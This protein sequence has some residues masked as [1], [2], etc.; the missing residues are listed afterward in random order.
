[1]PEIQDGIIEIESLAR[2]AGSRTKMAVSTH[3]ES[4]D[5]VGA[6]VGNRGIRVQAVVDELFGEKIDIIGW[7]DVTEDNISSAL[8]PAKAE[9]IVLD[10]ENKAATAIV[11]DYQ[12]S[13]AIG[14]E[15]QNVRLAAK[16]CGIKIDIK[17]HSQYFGEPQGTLTG[18]LD[19]DGYLNPADFIDY[20]PADKKAAQDAE[21]DDESGADAP[22]IDGADSENLRTESDADLNN[23]D[24][25]ADD[26]EAGAEAGDAD[27]AEAGDS[28][29]V[30]ASNA[31]ADADTNDAGDA[32]ADDAS[33]ADADADKTD[34]D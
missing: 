18:V 33:S 8:S 3:D 23:T 1:V 30:A 26:T 5:P 21:A 20:V 13:L 12:L 31:E 9:K 29:D 2:E 25:D 22:A 19:E 24:I 34:I 14:K 7:S 28:S 15:G 6:C 16:L 27:D 11:P 10:A 17:S 4:V 32:G